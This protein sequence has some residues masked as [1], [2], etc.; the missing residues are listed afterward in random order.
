[1][2]RE[3]GRG[4]EAVMRP[5]AF[6]VILL[7]GMPVAARADTKAAVDAD[8]QRLAAIASGPWR[9]DQLAQIRRPSVGGPRGPVM[10]ARA[11][12]GG[13]A[14]TQG[15]QSLVAALMDALNLLG[16]DAGPPRD[17]LDARGKSAIKAF[18]RDHDLPQSGRVSKR[19]VAAVTRALEAKR[20]SAGSG[21]QANA[22]SRPPR[23][24][25]SG[26]GFVVSAAGHVLTNNHVV[27]GCREMRVGDSEVL[28]LV[29]ADKSAD[30]AILKLRQPRPAAASFRDGSNA[31]PG[32]DIVV[33]GYPLHGLLGADAI[34]TTGIINALAG[35]RNDRRLIQI[36]APVQ[37][38]NSGGPVLDS[39]GNIVG[40]VVAKLDALG[41]AKVTGDIP[42]NVNFA[43]NEA[44]AR[45]FLDAHHVGYNLAP[46]AGK[47]T[48]PDVAS[49]AS[50]FTLLLEC[51]K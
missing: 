44:T 1:M 12:T 23:P 10:V 8:E 47:L 2:I 7:L 18:Q 51:F 43:I 3:N 31:R 24:V 37:P 45:S 19:L 38:G 6:A 26:T 29:A 17:K 42:E 5:L 4:R 48:A 15:P 16:Y 27:E 35:I 14:A 46:S 21:Q 50:R 22:P 40:V 34:V 9:A 28:D 49:K 13:A 39:S 32:E 30:L 11:R 25:A 33:L 41:V 36:S 20:E